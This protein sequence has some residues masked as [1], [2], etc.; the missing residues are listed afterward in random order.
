M[1]NKCRSET[2][3]RLYP[4]PQV[5]IPVIKK[6]LG[7]SRF[8]LVGSTPSS[9]GTVQTSTE[10]RTR[11]GGRR[12]AYLGTEDAATRETGARI[13]CFISFF[14]LSLLD[15]PTFHLTFITQDLMLLTI[16]CGKKSTGELSRA[17]EKCLIH[18]M[19]RSLVKQLHAATC[20]ILLF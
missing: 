3:I 9:M 10:T 14:D 4:S 8:H 1:Q 5:S 11:M 6:K 16:P 2:Q 19:G 18:N 15:N 7:R 12:D 20:I 13:T 17:N